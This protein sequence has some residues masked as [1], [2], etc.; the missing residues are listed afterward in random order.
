[1]DLPRQSG[2]TEDNDLNDQLVYHSLLTAQGPDELQAELNAALLGYYNDLAIWKS[3]GYPVP[4]A[5]QIVSVDRL[6]YM[7]MDKSTADVCM[8]R[9]CLVHNSSNCAARVTSL[10]PYLAN[11]ASTEVCGKLNSI[12]DGSS[13]LRGPEL[14]RN[15]YF[16][17][18][19]PSQC[20]E[21][22]GELSVVTV[23]GGS[24]AFDVSTRQRQPNDPDEKYFRY[25]EVICAGPSLFGATM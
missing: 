15:D 21:K 22:T 3:C 1:M 2:A 8:W 19:L 13:E 24:L 23:D 20:F 14:T 6:L 11:V 9:R 4:D 17:A 18:L 25:E 7:Y 16:V 5:E 10:P 12:I